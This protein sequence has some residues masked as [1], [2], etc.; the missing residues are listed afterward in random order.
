MTDTRKHP[1]ST[2]ENTATDTDTDTV[3]DEE[4]ELRPNPDNPHYPYT[5]PSQS[6]LRSGTGKGILRRLFFED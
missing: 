2:N 4:D 1:D 5:D 3:K 6:A